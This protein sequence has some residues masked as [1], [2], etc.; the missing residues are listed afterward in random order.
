MRSF[1]AFWSLPHPKQDDPDPSNAVVD[2]GANHCTISGE[3]IDGVKITTL[4]FRRRHRPFAST[5][6]TTP[7]HLSC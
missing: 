5:Q 7:E 4:L 3:K 2:D 1:V 6:S